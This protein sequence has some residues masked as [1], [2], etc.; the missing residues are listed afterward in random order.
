[1]KTKFAIVLDQFANSIENSDFD[2][3][4]RELSILN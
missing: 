3:K 1:M 2:D 4:V